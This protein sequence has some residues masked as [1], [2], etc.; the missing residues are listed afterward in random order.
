[1]SDRIIVL[2]IEVRER[3]RAGEVVERP[4]SVV[5]E[6]IENSIDA[7][8]RRIIC[9]I[10]RGGVERIRVTDDG[11]GMSPSDAELALKRYSTSKIKA[12]D[13]IYHIQTFGFR[14]EALPSIKAVSELT[15]ETRPSND[16]IGFLIRTRGNEIIEKRPQPMKVGTIVDVRRLFF[17]TPARRKFIKSERVEFN[18]IKKV[19]TALAIEHKNIHFTLFNNGSLSLD[20]PS[21][22]DLKE[23]LSY[24]L[25]ANLLDNLLFFSERYDNIEIKGTTVR[26]EH[27]ESLRKFQYI[28]VNGR[29][30]SSNLVRKAIYQAYG[31]SLWGKH[32]VFVVEINLPSKDIDVNIHPTKKEV[33]FNKENE[34]FRNTFLAIKK[35]L[36]SK[37]GLPE[38]EKEKNFLLQEELVQSGQLTEQTF[39]QKVGEETTSYRVGTT[40]P[41][42]F[43]QLHNSYI[44]ASTKTGFMIVD[45]H[46]A[47]ERIIFDKI[48]G[49]K[50]PIP[51]QMLLFPIKVDLTID[52][53]E[54]FNENIESFFEVGFRIKRFSGR[55]VIVEG[56]PPFMK[57]IDEE[58]IHSLLKD[59]ID[60]VSSK[61]VFSEVAKQVA[62]KSAI[63]AGQMLQPE[64]MNKLF[65]D[66]FATDNPYQCPHGRPTMIKFTLDEL[67]KK[68]K[69][70]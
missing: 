12:I 9:E 21:C 63:K 56:I 65:D 13:D 68:F 6:L 37:E 32:P 25:E 17:N 46:A 67:E 55:T 28:F 34:I 18:H 45:Q 36:I 22:L 42:G 43:W 15:L 51:P 10:I 44:F 64:E 31:N 54:F 61:E 5:K 7:G 60:N 49:R 47:H 62:C 38:L 40:V 4:A 20:L 3:I 27:A 2:P 69:R 16:E 50:E 26:P 59:I 33:R 41:K 39:F 19:F 11:E 70:K 14:G 57:E 8:S 29:W 24:I 58:V 66:L 1:M 30:V 52:E 53:E 23:R 48:M 35:I